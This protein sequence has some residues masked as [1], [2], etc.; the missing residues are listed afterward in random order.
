M[1]NGT[2]PAAEPT[3]AEAAAMMASRRY[4]VLLVAASIVGVM[5]SFAT[6][7]PG[8]DSDRTRGRGDCVELREQ[9]P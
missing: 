3:A 9:A 2:S 7:L 6:W 4:V 8:I 1:A 5:V